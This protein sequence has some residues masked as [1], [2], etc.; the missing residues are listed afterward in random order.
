[1]GRR[2]KEPIHVA[3]HAVGIY[4][5]ALSESPASLATLAELAFPAASVVLAYF[6][7]DSSLELTQWI[8]LVLVSALITLLVLA[9]ENRAGV[10][11]PPADGVLYDP[12]VQRLAVLSSPR[13][14]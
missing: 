10:K 13:D 6:L 8:G 7:L 1:V 11:A 14:G 5:R 12:L 2:T 9:T 3:Q 4:Y